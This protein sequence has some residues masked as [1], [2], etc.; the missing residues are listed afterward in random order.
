MPKSRPPYDPEFR[1][2][3]IELHRGGRSAK[4]LAA[5]FGCT[6]QSVRNWSKQSGGASSAPSGSPKPSGSTEERAELERLRREVRV[7]REE[8]DILKKA[9]A[10]FA[11]EA[12]GT[13]RRR[14]DS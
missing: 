11:Q 1:Q 9:A 10:W 4:S 12:A 6:E 2:K 7:L 14:T 3:L 13:P 8:R 5:E